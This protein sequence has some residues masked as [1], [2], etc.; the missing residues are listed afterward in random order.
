MPSPV[1]MAALVVNGK[2][3]PQPPVQRMTGPASDRAHPARSQ[4]DGHAPGSAVF[5]EQ[6]GDEPLVVPGCW[7]F[8]EVWKS[9]CSMWKPVL[10]A[11]NHVR[12]FF[13]PPKGRTATRPSGSRLQGQP[14]CSSCSSSRGASLTNARRRPGRRASRCPRSCRR[15]G[16]RAVVVGDD[17]GSAALR[18]HRVAAHRVD[19][20]DHGHVEP[21]S[22]LGDGDGGAESSAAAADQEYVVVGGYRVFTHPGLLVHQH[23]AVVV[24]DLPVEA[25]V[26][27]LLAVA[28]ATAGVDHVLGDCP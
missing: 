2:T 5:D 15:R 1:L 8:S 4:L 23:L 3:R 25:P 22:G 24:D 6:P 21:G 9:V 16:R 7:Y 17:A 12:W 13:M 28:L 27:E 18:R 14:Q 26:V 10:S 19:L 20:G 11:A